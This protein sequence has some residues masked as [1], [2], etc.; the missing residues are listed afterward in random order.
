MSVPEMMLAWQVSQL[1]EPSE[2]MMLSEVAVPSP[3]PGQ[4]LV[5]VWSTALNFP[6]VLLSRGQYQEQP[7]LPFTP[8]LE[9]CGM[10]VA[11]GPG[12]DRSRIGERVIG[13]PVLPHGALAR[14]ALAAEAELYTAPPGLDDAAASAMHIAYQTGWFGLYRRAALRV[15]ET[16]LVN[17]AAG[18]VGS[19]ATQLAKAAGARVIG[20]VGGGA[21]ADVARMLGADIVIDRT[22]QDVVEAVRSATG[23]RGVDVVYDPVG[24]DAYGMAARVVAFEGRIVVVGFAG[25]TITEVTLN[26][27]L[28][29]NY[30]IIG[31][32][33]GLYRSKDP[34]VV[35]RAHDDLCNLVE[36][37]G[38]RPLVSERLPF[39]EA[40]QGLARL[41]KGETVGRITVLPP[42]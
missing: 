2:V 27:V 26:H 39:E 5:E 28:L 12:V 24:G 1:G 3:G 20:V 38:V 15:G 30:T 6:D 22:T 11:V 7:A 8:G 9:F 18:G 23:G 42:T 36:A 40:G 29:K 33:W 31:L 13:T 41:G 35:R 32:H 16:L 34:R 25:G 37:G 4:A 10:V 14:Y 19:A 17:A 21:K